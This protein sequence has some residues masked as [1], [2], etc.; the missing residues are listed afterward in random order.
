MTLLAVCAGLLFSVHPCK[1][2]TKMSINTRRIVFVV[3]ILKI[4]LIG[5][6]VWF[7]KYK[8]ITLNSTLAPSALRA[9]CSF[10]QTLLKNKGKAVNHL[11]QFA[12]Y[13]TA[14]AADHL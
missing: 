13:W 5:E 8:Q 2:K 4:C 12:R 14:K 11:C 9:S 6:P 7:S 10:Y 3:V 1:C